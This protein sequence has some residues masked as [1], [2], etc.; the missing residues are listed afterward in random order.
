MTG[1]E[2]LSDYTPSRPNTVALNGKRFP[3]G[4]SCH[5]LRSSQATGLDR[6]LHNGPCL[7]STSGSGPVRSLRWARRCGARE[8]R[9][10]MARISR[11]AAVLG[12][13][14]AGLAGCSTAKPP[15]APPS[16]PA[17]PTPTP[18]ATPSA[19]PS[20]D[21]RPRWPLTGVLLKHPSDAHHAAVAVKVPDN[22]E[23]HPQRGID[24]ADIVFV[25]LE[26]YLAVTATAR[27][28]R[29][30]LPFTDA[31]QRRARPLDPSGRTS[32]CSAR[33]TRSSA[34]PVARPG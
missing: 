7:A 17:S 2:G 30:G 12:V 10:L 15:A 5:H 20:V 18:S 19:T 21:S 29:P 25:E 26:G 8:R 23:E 34:T 28:A 32:R 1:S 11:R 3:I 31:G 14:G 33:W 4:R 22:R 27:P 16:A 13:L 6:N 24:Q 9:M